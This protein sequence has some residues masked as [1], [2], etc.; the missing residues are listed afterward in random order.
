[1]AGTE[2]VQLYVRSVADTDGP[3]LSLKGFT[4]VDLKAGEERTVSFDL[5]DPK[6][7]ELFDIDTNTMRSKPGKYMLY[8]GT[9]SAGGDLQT[10]EYEKR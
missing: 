10:L 2:T 7:F 3:R 6:I 9:S 1:M 4:R 5:N 8:Y